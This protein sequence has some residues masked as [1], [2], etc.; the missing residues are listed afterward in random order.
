MVQ[1][2]NRIAMVSPSLNAYSET[3]I[4]EQ[5]NGLEGE[6]FY[7]YGGTLPTHLENSGKLISY[8]IAIINKIKRKI[9]L[10]TF[11][12]QET[13]FIVSLKQQKIKV[14]LAQYGTTAHRIVKICKFLKI[15]KLG[16]KF[17]NSE[18]NILPASIREIKA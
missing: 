7:Y 17:L 14:V 5:K 11:N 18:S 6:V 3:F 12:A 15:L 2:K 10:T 13:A 16:C 4:Q 8:S 1:Q 9:K